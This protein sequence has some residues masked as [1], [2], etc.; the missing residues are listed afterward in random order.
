M[1]AMRAGGRS[2]RDI[3]SAVRADG[4]NVSHVAVARILKEAEAE[5]RAVAA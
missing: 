3:A 4:F 1:Q 2:L 5:D